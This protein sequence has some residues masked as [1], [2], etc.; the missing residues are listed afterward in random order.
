LLAE[1]ED[2]I[3]KD[4]EALRSFLSAAQ[5]RGG[6][7]VALHFNAF[8]TKTL[9]RFRSRRSSTRSRREV[10]I[11]S[12]ESVRNWHAKLSQRRCETG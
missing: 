10:R 4:C 9:P 6:R 2:E 1:L 12:S 11:P 7:P 3:E 8:E 5:V